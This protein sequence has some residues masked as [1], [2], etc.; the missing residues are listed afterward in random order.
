ML[1]TRGSNF[2]GAPRWKERCRH[3]IRS[4][5]PES[6]SSEK[7]Q[8]VGSVLPYR[9]LNWDEAIHTAQLYA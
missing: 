1:K 3:L 6:F 9:T 8:L 5:G 7:G 4:Q 2:S